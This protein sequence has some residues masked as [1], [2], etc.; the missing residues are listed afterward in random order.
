MKKL[1]LLF[2]LNLL[3]MVVNATVL[4]DGIYYDIYEVS[5]AAAVTSFDSDPSKN[6]TAYTGDNSDSTVHYV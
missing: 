4:I 6:G 3:S 5:C 2:V 1:L